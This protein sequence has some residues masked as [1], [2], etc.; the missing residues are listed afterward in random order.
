MVAIPM[1]GIEHSYFFLFHHYSIVYLY[2]R[3]VEE[4]IKRAPSMDLQLATI[5]MKNSSNLSIDQ[6][7][8]DDDDNGKKKYE[9]IL[10]A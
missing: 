4:M 3:G 7:G 1:I 8:L 6:V 2:N 9:L 5:L 10:K